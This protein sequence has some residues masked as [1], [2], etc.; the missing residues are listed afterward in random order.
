MSLPRPIT[1]VAS[2][3]CG[4]HRDQ[5]G[6]ISILSTFALLMFTMLLLLITNVA[7]QVDD[8]VKM[9]NA[10]DSAAYSGGVVIA[11]GMN[12]IAFANHLEADVLALT[13]F[14]REARDRNAE[15]LIPEVLAAWKSAGAAFTPAEFEKFRPL[16]GAIPDKADKEQ[17]LVTAWSEM[18]YSASEYALPIFEHILGTP[19]T[20][21]YPTEDH[22]IPNFQTAV[23]ETIP[24]Y[25]QEVTHEITLRHGL[26]ADQPGSVGT[27][28]RYN[29]QAAANG[30]GPQIG[31]LWR[32]NALP[33]SIADETDPLTRTLPIIDPT[34]AGNDFQRLPNGQ[35]YFTAAS[36]RRRDLA[37]RYLSAWTQNEP[38]ILK[39]MGFF[40]SEAKM[41]RFDDFFQM[42]ACAQLNQLLDVEYPHSNIPFM[43]RE[44][45][46]SG[47]VGNELLER[48]YTFV[49][50]AYRPNVR[51]MAP[52]MFE[53]P[54]EARETDAL[55]FAQIRLYIPRSRFA[56]CP[57]RVPHYNLRDDFLGDSLHTDG[58]SNEWSS[59]NQNW[60]VSLEPA[61]AEGL[62]EIL[63]TNPGG[64]ASEVRPP[65]LGG[66]SLHDLDAV[67]TH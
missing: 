4:V 59:F 17:A 33:V 53:N 55:T 11:R 39:G 34:P 24:T 23:L 52:R 43:L 37:F 8:K 45:V 29:P 51:E 63:Q 60:L 48:D 21:G 3:L 54:L 30:R 66:A 42:A 22:L 36:S 47:V 41:S 35:A 65:N 56:C 20:E 25:A 31:V 46:P 26:P 9:Q 15:S 13:A 7:Q 40:N 50:V 12:A 19:E 57:W 67:N 61:V 32:T 58:W 64:Y 16:P 2:R 44:D 10:A 49:A 6:T 28:L 1:L 27:Q 38:D 18:A 14:L 62:P 5:R